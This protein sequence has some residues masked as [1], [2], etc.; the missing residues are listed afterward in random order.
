MMKEQN[1]HLLEPGGDK[2]Y[3]L[4]LRVTNPLVLLVRLLVQLLSQ[5]PTPV[6]PNGN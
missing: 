1:E 3:L 5:E 4:V 2:D 6:L